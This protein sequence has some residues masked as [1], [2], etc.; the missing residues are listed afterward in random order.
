MI[1]RETIQKIL[2]SGV[3]APSGSNSQPWKF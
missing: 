3:Q 2:E 1:P